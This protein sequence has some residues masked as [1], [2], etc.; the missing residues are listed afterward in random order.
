MNVKQFCDAISG[1]IT[2]GQKFSEKE[3]TGGYTGDL[4]SLTI[5]KAKVGD[6]FITV[7][8]NVNT[9]AVASLADISCIVLSEGTATT[10]EM[11]EKAEMV[12][13]P[14]IES[15]KSSFRLCVLLAN[16][17]KE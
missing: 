11:K 14:I 4:L 7:M 17:L 10:N 1:K 16:L 13:I 8:N 15:T 9:V 5:S 3:I 2:A 12:K 6:A